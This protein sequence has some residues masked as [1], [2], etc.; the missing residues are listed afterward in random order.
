MSC[1]FFRVVFLAVGFLAVLSAGAPKALM[2]QYCT[3]QPA[4][5]MGFRSL[6]T[7]IGTV[8]TSVNKVDATIKTTAEEAKLHNKDLATAATAHV[9]SGLAQVVES[10]KMLATH[11]SSQQEFLALKQM[12]QQIMNTYEPAAQPITIAGN[13]EMG[14]GYQVARGTTA[15]SGETMMIK[16]LERRLRY[17]LPAEYRAAILNDA[18]GPLDDEFVRNLGLLE[19]GITLT[20]EENARNVKVMEFITNSLPPAILSDD[21]KQTSAG[22]NYEILKKNYETKQAIFQAVLTRYMT[23]RAP[24]VGGLSKWAGGKWVDMGGS[25]TPPGV[26]DGLMSMDALRWLLANF[27]LASANYHEE[28]L[29]TLNE[30]GLLRDIASSQ[31]ISLELQRKQVELLENISLMMAL[32]GIQQLEVTDRTLLTTAYDRVFSSERK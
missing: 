1:K 29:P 20:P 26:V 22:Q 7:A 16:I 5:S 3:C 24:T 10:I 15:E 31:A 28:L 19:P 12:E 14:A 17:S 30:A 32:G 2:A 11:L 23:E 4:M 9:V 8:N 18:S 6:E 27:R 25:G 21:L 13:D